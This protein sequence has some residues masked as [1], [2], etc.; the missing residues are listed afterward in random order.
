MN[1]HKF[2]SDFG[3]ELSKSGQKLPLQDILFKGKAR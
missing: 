1:F 2:M 3:Q